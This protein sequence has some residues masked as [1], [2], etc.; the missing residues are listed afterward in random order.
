MA[1]R[2]NGKIHTSRRPIRLPKGDRYITDG[3]RMA[4]LFCCNE[5]VLGANA[6]IQD[7]AFLNAADPAAP[8][9]ANLN[10]DHFAGARYVSLPEPDS[11]AL[12]LAGF[13][14]LAVARKTLR[15]P[16]RPASHRIDAA[17]KALPNPPPG[18]PP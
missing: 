2:K 18:F 12:F 6:S 8:A 3:T 15:R 4:R 11:A 13:L 10:E 14:A 7:F 16:E 1:Y 9:L 5:Y 17:A